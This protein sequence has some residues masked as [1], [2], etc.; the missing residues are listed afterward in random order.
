MNRKSAAHAP[1]VS[2][3]FAMAALASLPANGFAQSETGRP[4]FDAASVKVNESG[5]RPSTRYDPTRVDLR[6][7]SIKHLVRRAWQLPDYQIVWPAWVDD[8]TRQAWI[9][10]FGYLPSRYEPQA[11]EPHV[12]GSA[13]D[14]FRTGDASG[15]S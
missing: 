5:D 4:Q 15:N 14:P 10:C 11:A 2:I 1:P 7:A 9:R 3:W 12:S 6:K 13:R 8:A